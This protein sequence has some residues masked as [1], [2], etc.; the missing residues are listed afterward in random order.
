MKNTTLGGLGQNEP[1]RTQVQNRQ[2]ERKLNCDRVL[3][4]YLPLCRPEEQTQTNPIKANL[5]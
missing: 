2:N 5:W 1:K 4:E 3:R